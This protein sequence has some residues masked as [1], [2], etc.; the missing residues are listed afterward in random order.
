[1]DIR[2]YIDILK[3]EN[4][5]VKAGM[6]VY[7]VENN[8]PYMAFMVSSNSDYGG[9]YPAI[10]KGNID[11][12][13]TEKQ[14]AIREMNE[15]IGI[16]PK[17]LKKVFHVET[18]K[19]YELDNTYDLRLFG[20]LLNKKENTHFGWETKEVK[21]FSPNEISKIKKSHQPIVKTFLNFIQY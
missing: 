18:T 14:A 2:K 17:K 5:K 11:K 1:M 19:I 15:E 21:W 6:I 16:D 12:G 4:K 10:S 3:E 8:I 13:E 9:P 20:G 7:Y